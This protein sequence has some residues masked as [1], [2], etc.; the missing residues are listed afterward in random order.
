MDIELFRD[1]SALGFQ[2]CLYLVFLSTILI[3]N[4]KLYFY[5]IYFYMVKQVCKL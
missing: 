4:S 5:G 3:I 1:I 2:F